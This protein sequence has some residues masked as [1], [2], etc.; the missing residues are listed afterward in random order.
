MVTSFVDDILLPFVEAQLRRE[1]TPDTDGRVQGLRGT[2]LVA[3]LR[4]KNDALIATYARDN[5]LPERA[6]LLLALLSDALCDYTLRGRE[7]ISALHVLYPRIVHALLFAGGLLVDRAS[8]LLR[9]SI[10]GHA[11]WTQIKFF[12]YEGAVEQDEC[13][14][15]NP[16]HFFLSS[17]FWLQRRYY[18]QP[19]FAELDVRADDWADHCIARNIPLPIL[20]IYAQNEFNGMSLYEACFCVC[21]EH[22][23]TRGWIIVTETEYSTNRPTK[24]SVTS[25]ANATVLGHIRDCL[26]PFFWTLDAAPIWDTILCM[27]ATR[28]NAPFFPWEGAWQMDDVF[29]DYRYLNFNIPVS[30]SDLG[31]ELEHYNLHHTTEDELDLDDISFENMDDE[32]PAGDASPVAAAAAPAEYAPPEAPPPPPARLD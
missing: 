25:H 1:Q 23:H 24:F 7:G 31:S 9:P 19:P 14:L 6:E 21:V 2:R 10:S 28:N 29:E 26:P 4:L 3:Q 13:A 12:A 20:P 22:M 30:P 32:D 27:R 8:P 5:E 18:D 11:M 17:N 15:N 16:C